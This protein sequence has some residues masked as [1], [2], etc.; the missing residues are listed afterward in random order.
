MDESAGGRCSARIH[1]RTRGRKCLQIPCKN[2]ASALGSL[3]RAA[4]AARCH[5]SQGD[6]NDCR[7]AA[8]AAAGRPVLMDGPVGQ[9]QG[10]MVLNYRI[11]G[12]IA[13]LGPHPIPVAHGIRCTGLCAGHFGLGESRQTAIRV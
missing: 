13:H 8:N 10:A 5:P 4:H 3:R 12:R 9:S 11:Q 6:K 2:R 7:F 1:A